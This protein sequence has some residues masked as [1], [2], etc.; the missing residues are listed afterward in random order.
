MRRSLAD[1][2]FHSAVELFA[3]YVGRAADFATWLEDAK[4]NTDRNFRLQ[5]LAGEGFNV[6]A[7]DAIFRDM[8]ALATKFPE[9]L[10]SGS[11]E[12]LAQLRQRIESGGP[13]G[14]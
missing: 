10:F 13:H 11:P 8:T 5:Y 2:G 6:Y 12:L 4:L 3:T 9:D 1:V 14:R 7:A